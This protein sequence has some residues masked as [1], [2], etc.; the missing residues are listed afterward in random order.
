MKGHTGLSRGSMHSRQVLNRRRLLGGLSGFAIG[1]GVGANGVMAQSAS[2]PAPSHLPP[3]SAAQ[4]WLGPPALM[5]F[6]ACVPDSMMDEDY[7]A[8][9]PWFFADIEQQFRSRG[10]GSVGKREYP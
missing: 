2:E 7:A 8:D 5:E 10:L 3:R 9:Y 1:G 6:L 4:D